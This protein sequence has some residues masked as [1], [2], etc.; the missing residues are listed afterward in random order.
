MT[1]P[2]TTRT[3]GPLHL[4]DLEPHRFEDLIRQLLYDF[5]DWRQLEATGRAGSDEG[6]DVYARERVGDQTSDSDGEESEEDGLPM[7]AERTWLIQC[8][9]ERSI[10]PKKLAKYLDAIPQ[11]GPPLHGIIFA[12]AC[13]FSKTSRDVFREKTRQRGAQEAFLWGKAEIEDMLF[14]PKND[15]LLFAYFGFSLQTRRRSLKADIRA[16]LATKRKALNRLEDWMPLLVRDASDERYPYLDSDKSKKRLQRGRWNVLRYKGAFSDGLRFLWKRHFAFLDDDGKSWDIAET[17]DDGEIDGHENPWTQDRVEDGEKH[18]RR[19]EAM[20]V[21]EALPEANRAWF[22]SVLVLPYEN[23]LDIDE[24]G[25]EYFKNPHIYTGPFGQRMGPFDDR[26]YTSV[27]TISRYGAR[28]LYP[29][30]VDRVEKFVRA[31]PAPKA[32]RKKSK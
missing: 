27:E 5:R 21:W 16:R 20:T 12:A 23:I 4:E 17:T 9:R 7:P 13:D 26:V 1:G 32:K 29:M 24:K 28:S 14:Q 31:T 6:F 30:D 8:K 2:I 3:I 10:A 11:D 15:H 22:E 25:D 18:L 19:N